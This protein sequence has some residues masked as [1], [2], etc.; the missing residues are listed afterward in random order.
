VDGTG[1]VPAITLTRTTTD[2]LRGAG[3]FLI[4]KDAANRQGEGAS[5]DFTTDLATANRQLTISF[6]AEV[7]AGYE[8]GD[9]TIHVYDVTNG[10]L[11]PISSNNSIDATGHGTLSFT[12]NSST[13]YRLIAHIATTNAAAWTVKL[14][15][16]SVGPVD[17]VSAFAGSDW[18]EFTP[19]I[20]NVTTS[21]IEGRWRRVGDSMEVDISA[22]VASVSGDMHPALPSGYAVDASKLGTVFL[23]DRNLV[24]TASAWDLSILRFY[25]GDITYDLGDDVLKIVSNNGSL[26]WDASV[27]F[28]WASGDSLSLRFTVP[29]VGWSGSQAVQPGH[30]FRVAERYGA[31]F[32]TVTGADPAALGEI[33]Y[34]RNGSDVTPTHPA[35]VAD[36]IRL[37]ANP[38]AGE[39]NEARVFVGR[40]KSMPSLLGWRSTGRANAVYTEH[41]YLD[42]NIDIGV[43]REYD[44][45]TGILVLWVGGNSGDLAARYVSGS[46]LTSVAT[47]YLEAVVSDPVI[48]VALAPAVHVE[49]EH[50]AGQVVTANTTDFAYTAVRDTHGIWDGSGANISVSGPYVLVASTLSP[51]DDTRIQVYIDGV[52]ANR[53]MSN[54]PATRESTVVVSRWFEAGQRV[55]IRATRSGTRSTS[56][57]AE[58]FHLTF[59][60]A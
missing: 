57:A 30:T 45:A 25:S 55:S 9:L 17:A 47:V 43:A 14:D 40:G 8:A 15:N 27:P 35:S 42:S 46:G 31:T 21:S 5:T 51:A 37:D 18:T 20:A 41:G 12:T 58:F 29:I 7:S 4:T 24:G 52:A 53:G 28:T 32:T 48:P 6:D 1:G 34:L 56:A 26:D 13:S 49:A 2:P 39:A 11:T 36:G 60:G 22:V 16:V 44:P 54:D 19:T 23:V 10:N 3:S 38:G 33:R 50:T 59:L